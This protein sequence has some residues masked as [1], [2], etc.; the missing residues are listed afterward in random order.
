MLDT[1]NNKENLIKLMQENPDLPV[2]FMV[3][4]DY[5]DTDYST[6]LLKDFRAYKCV[7]YEYNRFGDLVYTDDKREVVE[8]F[9]DYFADEDQYKDVPQ[10]TYEKIIEKYVD[11]QILNYPAIAIYVS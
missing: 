10:D 5:I 9:V 11:E 2:V 4:T 3:Y 8:Y 6:I 1:K 7:L